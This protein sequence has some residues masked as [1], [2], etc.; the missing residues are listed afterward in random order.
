MSH[1]LRTPL[2]SIIGFT[3]VVL[4]GHAGP[5]TDEQR[6]QLGMVR[7]S[8]QHLLALINQVLELSR[9]EHTGPSVLTAIL[10]IG[11]AARRA[12]ETLR[13]LAEGKGLGL[14]V[15]VS[16]D[17]PQI[18]TDRLRLDQILYNLVGNAIKFTEC[19]SV[20]I[21]VDASA[22]GNVRF[23]VADTGLGI[24]PEE[25]S[26]IFEDFYQMVPA[27]GGKAGGTGLGLSISRRLAESLG[28]SIELESEMGCGSAFTL[29]LP[30]A[31][32]TE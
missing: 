7:D 6:R 20:S 11:A 1:E 13:P 9:L 27:D 22:N 5:L 28:G 18:S 30:A 29:V 8:G 31:P 2:N 10:D 16:S 12:A 17:L 15:N 14:T 23:T 32:P 19:G 21:S 25:Q 3:G 24:P 26:N 4:Q